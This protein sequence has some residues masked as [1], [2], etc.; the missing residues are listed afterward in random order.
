MTVNPQA[1]NSVVVNDISST[2]EDAAINIDVLTNDTDVDGT[3]PSGVASVTQ[4]SNGSVSI[5]PDGTV[6]YTPNPDYN[7][8]DSFTYTNAEG[9]VGT[10][11]MTVN[12]QAD[13]PVVVSDSYT[14]IEGGSL[15]E[16]VLTGILANDSDPDGGAINVVAFATNMSG[17]GQSTANGT[18]VVT[19]VLGGTVIISADGSFTYTAPISLDHSTSDNLVDSFAYHISDGTQS[20][21]WTTVNINVSDTF[22]VAADDNDSV[23]FGGTIYGNVITGAGGDGTGIDSIGQDGP[24]S[25]TSVSF[26][27]AVYSGFDGAGDL[28]IT[29]A[30]GSLTI[31]QSGSY[32]YTSS[33]LV[34]G[35][36]PDDIFSY[37]FE[38]GDGDVTSADLTMSHDNI[39]AAITDTATVY[40]SGMASGTQAVTTLETT[41]ADN[42][43]DNDTGIGASTLISQITF[44]GTTVT[45]SSGVVIIDGAYGTLTVY[46][47]D[48]GSIRAGDYS[49]TMTSASSGDNT[50]E[51]FQYTLMDTDTGNLSSSNL[52][53]SIVDD[54][55]GGNDISQN[56]AT[57]AAPLIYNLSIVLDVS[58]SMSTLTPNGDT[59]LEAATSAIESLI[60]GTDDLGNVNVQIIAFS[61][62]VQSSGWYQ[63]DVY[64]ALDFLNSLQAG[65]GTYYDSALNAVINSGTPPVADQSLIYFVSDGVS[66]NN[67]G[68]DNSITYTNGAGNALT[69]QAAWE[70]YVDENSDIAFGIG[71]GSANLGELEQVAHPLVGGS[72]QYAIAVSD[73][74]DLSATLLET[75]SNNTVAGS[76]EVLGANGAYGFV[77]GADGGYVSSIVVD[78]VTH[79]YDPLTSTTSILTLTTALGGLL[80]FDLDSGEYSYSLDV[81]QAVLGQ[82]ELFPVAVMDNDGD[83]YT[84]NIQFNINY[85]PSIDANQDI[86]ITNIS[87]GSVIN[88]SDSALTHNDT[89]P[90]GFSLSST[91]NATSGTV[92]GT[93]N[94]SFDP[95]SAALFL[96]ETDFET[97]NQATSI[98]DRGESTAQNNTLATATDFSIRSLF[99]SNDG[100]LSGVNVNGYSAAYLGNIYGSGDQDWISVTLAQGENL[101]L[102]VDNS[103]VLVNASVYDSNGDFVSIVANNSGGPWGGYTASSSGTYYVVVEAQADGNDGNYDLFMTINATNAD[104]SSALVGGFDYTLDNG[105]GVQDSTSVNVTAVSG[106]N[107]TG[108]SEDEILVSGS[109]GDILV[110]NAGDDVLMGHEGD[111]TLQ[112]GEGADLL[113][114]GTGSDSLIGGAG[115]DIFAL[116]AGD[117]GVTGLTIDTIEGFTVGTGGDVLDLSDMLSGENLGNL[118]NY[119]EFSYDAV[120]NSTTIA[121]DTTGSG[122]LGQQIVLGNV[123][124]T[125]N[126]NLSDQQ[127]LDN[128]LSTNNLIVDI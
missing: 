17:G 90:F 70:S 58:G 64:S 43:L 119:F 116:E 80:T 111:D 91:E 59:R 29:T 84:A 98:T 48:S 75:L 8:L 66:S 1:D 103:S 7:G 67:H 63:D 88:I 22:P 57:T 19:T 25:V 33:Q 96:A 95:A 32:S 71:I 26:D 39:S 31:N 82:T 125:L 11:N 93:T 106:S 3:A 89:A 87:D 104:Y 72:D 35:T 9:T 41:T 121:I 122:G 36:V 113:I 52:N 120:T 42:L 115:I 5:N 74:D 124:L 68:V 6:R 99:S 76:L 49:Y 100:N 24:G 46:T 12:P 107:I 20:S 79:L 114:G 112:G 101:W 65:G 118:D 94:I 28:S 38:D 27:G 69:G 16:G 78:G 109:G 92:T 45:P 85:E 34:L 2:N 102:D 73:T 97:I 23:G 77:I 4:G 10:V 30:N 56:L 127:I 110:G 86:I 54:A 40:E 81:N 51:T 60:A 61:G 14:I 83:S 62:S 13:I 15:I 126:G 117:E 105:A 123:D 108:G 21:A 55:P 128:L 37:T 47:A 44:S 50:S 18:N 53:I